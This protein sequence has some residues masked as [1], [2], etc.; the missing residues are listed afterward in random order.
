MILIGLNFKQNGLI[1]HKINSM[2]RN[3][4]KKKENKNVRTNY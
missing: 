3:I 1:K 4:I 2:F